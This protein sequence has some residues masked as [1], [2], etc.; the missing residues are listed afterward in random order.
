MLLQQLDHGEG[1]PRRHERAALFERV[2]PILNRVDDRG[3]RARPPDPAFF[4]S[5]RER[6]FAEATGRLRRMLLGRHVGA[7]ERFANRNVRQ[8]NFL[9]RKL[10]I[11]RVATFDIRPQIAGEID[12]FAAYLK[13]APFAFDGKRGASTARISHL[14]GHGA[15]PDHIE[16]L[17]LV[18]VQ[19]VA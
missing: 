11:R 4:E 17:E 2:V 10:S 14:A 15:L 16:D 19:L 7:L 9:I 6:R 18:G 5:F 1:N 12:R 3:V 13:H 8:H